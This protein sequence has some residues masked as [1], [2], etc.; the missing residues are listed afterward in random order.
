MIN[1]ATSKELQDVWVDGQKGS[2]CQPD[3]DN[4]G[5]ILFPQDDISDA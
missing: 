1:F 5:P 4:N 2:K 3:A